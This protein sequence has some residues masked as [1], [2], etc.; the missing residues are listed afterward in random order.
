MN[1][2][3]LYLV[4][5]SKPTYANEVAGYSVIAPLLVTRASERPSLRFFIVQGVP[6]GEREN[7]G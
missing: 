7:R 3:V 5:Q 1:Y 4:L 2:I 6:S